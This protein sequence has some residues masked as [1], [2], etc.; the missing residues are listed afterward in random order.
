MRKAKAKHSPKYTGEAIRTL[1]TLSEEFNMAAK[2]AK[3]LS[4]PSRPV[5]SSVP[6][7][8]TN[9]FASAR[10]WIVA[11]AKHMKYSGEIHEDMTKIKFAKKL[12]TRMAEAEAA[13]ASRA[14]IPSLGDKDASAKPARTGRSMPRAVGYRHIMN[15][16]QAWGLWPISAIE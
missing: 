13:A 16:L 10:D 12:A 9:Y 6:A 5:V 15:N 3:G 14:D 4:Q 2:L 11:T 8:R 7:V 1:A